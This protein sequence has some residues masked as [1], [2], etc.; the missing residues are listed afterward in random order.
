MG[1]QAR[2]QWVRFGRE[3]RRVRAQQGMTQQQLGKSVS[4]SYAMISAIERGVRG[5]RRDLVEQID[6][7][8]STKGSLLRLWETVGSSSGGFPDW[9]RSTADLEQRASEIKTSQ[10]LLIHGLL[11]TEGYARTIL[12]DGRPTD[13]EAEIDELVAGRLERQ[14]VMERDRPPSFLMVLDETAVRR[15]VGGREIMK[16]QLTRVLEASERS[17]VVVQ[18]LPQASA[19]NPALNGPFTLITAEETEIL[20]METPLSG[21]VIDAPRIVGQYGRLLG[22]IRGVALPPRESRVL[23]DTVRGEYS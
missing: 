20:Y 6:H 7:L 19:N 13:T 11:Q 12:R 10:P 21:T 17:H 1:D 16:A 4:V 9:F 2:A 5:A 3:L 22:D 15:P 23:I 18:V 14:A 8:L